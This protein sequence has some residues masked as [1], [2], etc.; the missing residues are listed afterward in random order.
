MSAYVIVDIEV[1]DPVGY[2]DYKRPAAPTVIQ[3]DGRHIV[4]GGAHETLEGNWHA[5]RLGIL[6]FPSVTRAR[7]W[8]NLPE[9]LI[10]ALP[11]VGG[12]IGPAGAQYIQFKHIPPS[13]TSP[14]KHS[15]R[16]ARIIT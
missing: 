9:H 7:E 15:C 1:T 6:E 2:D 8:L 4:R 16:N 10:V 13:T 3:Y 11:D 14:N 12:I 5:N